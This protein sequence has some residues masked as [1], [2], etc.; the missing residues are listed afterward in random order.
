MDSNVAEGARGAE[1]TALAL[2]ERLD[3]HGHV[4]QCM[5]VGRWPVRIGRSLAADMVV[6]D[7][8]LAPL[9]AELAADTDGAVR[10]TLGQSINGAQVDGHALQAGQSATLPASRTWRMG[11]STWRVRLASDP[12]PAELPLGRHAA[13]HHEPNRLPVW[14]QVL[15]LLL[16]SVLAQL[17]ERWLD[18]NPGTA[19]NSYLSAGLGA[20]GLTMGWSLF[21]ALGNKLFQGRLD[22]KAHLRLAL[23]YGLSW[24]LVDAALPL[25]AY[26]MDW[27]TLS[28]IAEMAGLGVICALIWAHLAWIMPAHRRGLMA[29]VLALYVSGVGLNVWINQQRTGQ[30]FSERYATALPPPSWRLV[31]MQPVSSLLDDARS[32]KASLDSQARRDDNDDEAAALLVE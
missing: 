3:R 7:P 2:I 6:D 30:Y 19:A 18:N 11:A 21:W 23:I 8:H 28:R 26:A 5:R 20:L 32:M 31:G 4:Q 16:L 9:H 15:P 10:L 1:A 17:F 12:L 14:R 13:L 24:T 22:F 25:L 29:G 27:P